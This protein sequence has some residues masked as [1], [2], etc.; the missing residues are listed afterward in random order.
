[1]WAMLAELGFS[2]GEDN[3]NRNAAERQLKLDNLSMQFASKNKN[4]DSTLFLIL[5]G[6]GLLVTIVLIVKTVK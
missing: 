1:M 5:V 4:I 3:T 6:L 2:M